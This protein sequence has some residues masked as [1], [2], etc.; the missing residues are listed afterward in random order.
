MIFLSPRYAGYKIWIESPYHKLGTQG[1]RE[2]FP[3]ICVKFENGKYV[4]EDEKIIEAL[5]NS[6]FCGVDFFVGDQDK[7]KEPSEEAKE[8]L[9][10]EKEAISLASLTCPE[11]GFV[12]KSEFGL[13]GHMRK[14]QK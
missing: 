5:T 11:C 8:E 10:K 14:H 9:A 1:M 7:V 12:A 13:K 6:R 3:G 2:F 4:T